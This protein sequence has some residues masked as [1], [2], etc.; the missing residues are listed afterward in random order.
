MPPPTEH[1]AAHPAARTRARKFAIEAWALTLL[2]CGVPAAANAGDCHVGTYALAD[3][4]IVDIGRTDGGLRWRDAEGRTGKLTDGEGGWRSTLGWTDRPDGIVVKF[5]DCRAGT[6][7]FGG[8]AG[9][10]VPYDVRETTF[11]S[12]GTTLHGRLVLPRGRASVPVVVLLHGSERHS[13]RDFDPLQRLFPALGVGAFVYDKRSTGASGGEYTQDFSLLADDAIAALHAARRLA[14]KRV[15]RIGFQGPSQGGW[16]APIAA[17]RERVDFVIVSFGLAVS[18]LHEDR[19]AMELQLKL[20]GHGPDVI[21]RAL[22]IGDAAARVFESEFTDGI[23]KFDAVR[24]RY[25]DEPWYA[26]V[27]GNFTWILLPLTPDQIRTEGAKFRWGTPF[28]YDP[29]PTL[30]RL[31]VPQLWVVGGLDVDA[32]SGDTVRRLDGLIANG[33]PVTRAI[34]P[35]AEHGMT[36]FETAADGERVSTRYAA[37]YFRLMADYARHGTLRGAY[38][39]AQIRNASA[40][41]ATSA[42]PPR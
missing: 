33:R 3:G 19:E 8:R 26:D 31:D 21:A 30:E 18:V 6:I 11:E 40:H 29:L 27:R 16:V 14:G 35:T 2:L 34:Y 9:R 41:G 32:P 17:S 37:G 4:S 28:A 39:A 42:R 25:R 10:A 24:A 15:A 22:K 12:H 7:D 38:G 36:E 13:A 5:G 23:E 1:R 20:K